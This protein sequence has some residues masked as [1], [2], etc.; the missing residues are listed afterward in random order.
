MPTR[1]LASLAPLLLLAAH[2]TTQAQTQ[3][4]IQAQTQTPTQPQTQI[5]PQSQNQP[6][7][8]PPASSADP[9][10]LPA[11]PQFQPLAPLYFPELAPSARPTPANV[12]IGGEQVLFPITAAVGQFQPADRAAATTR[13]IA[14]LVSDPSFNAQTITISDHEGGTDVLAGDLVLTTVTNRDADFD[15]T[16]RT[17]Q[18]VAAAHAAAIRTAVLAE[19]A[20]YSPRSLTIGAVKAAAATLAL[21]LLLIALRLG[22]GFFYTKIRNRGGNRIRSLRIQSLELL[23][24]E[25]ITDILLQ[26]ARAL[27]FALTL[28]LL[29]LFIPLVFSFFAKTHRFGHTLVGYVMA[30]VAPGWHAFFAYLPNLL[31]LVVIA[32]FTFQA[33]RITRFLFREIERGTIVWPG[34]YP[35]WALP[36]SRIV[37]LLLIAFALVL[38]FP[39]LPG[40][41]SLAFKG[42]SIFL[43]VLLSLGSSTA[44]A[45]IVAGILLTY[46]R[47]FRIGDRVQIADT[48]GDVI[49]K[50]LLATH[51]R[52]IK[53]VD[54]TVPNGLVLGSH[55]FNFSR[56]TAQNPLILNTSMTVGYDAPWRQVH[57][58]LIRA[59]TGIEGVLADPPPFVL[60]TALDDFYVRYQINA[61]T[62]APERM[63]QIYSE[64]N[65]RIQDEFNAVGLEI[66]SPHYNALRHG[67]T[68][69]I[70]EEYLAE[71]STRDSPRHPHTMGQNR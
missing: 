41:N 62:S 27:R 71:H 44:I 20:K 13:K 32:F 43:G 45:N 70:P 29:Y 67:E 35:E 42:V 64:L 9:T 55:I 56:S 5:Q 3:P 34:F 23:S 15:A 51:V 50:T 28:L 7:T 31:V 58:L 18:A 66:M 4:Q 22:F 1:F 40:S 2:A 21:V 36:T 16:G 69:T 48:I 12:T 59:A 52:T 11:P 63:A 14:Q 47:A 17:R 61:Y 33:Y 26:S 68:T 46:T 57:Q 25:R 49:E 37:E 53:N 30:P 10:L 65:E 6:Q 24:K 19:K 8:Q 39:Y 38:A 60:Q 54:V